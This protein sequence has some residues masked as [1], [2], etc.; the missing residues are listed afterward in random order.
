MQIDPKDHD[1]ARIYQLMTSVIA[2]RPIAWVSTVSRDGVVNLAPFSYFNGVTSKPP[3]VS[4]AVGRRR[5]GAR[6]DTAHNASTTR[7]LVINVV[8][9]AELDT[10]VA[11]SAEHPPEVD[12]LALAKLT[13]VP[14]VT[15]KPPRVAEA[16]IQLECR[17]HAIYEVSPGIVDLLIAEILLVH[18]ADGLTVRDDL[19]IDAQSYRPV[20]RLGGDDYTTL[21][22]VRQVKRPR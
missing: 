4:I 3:L 15:V 11:T 18:V 2:P 14:S 5:G 1:P 17:T 10:M 13:P 20:A 12:E 22:T 21:G 6:K 7:E 9:E 16:P 19:Y 8:T